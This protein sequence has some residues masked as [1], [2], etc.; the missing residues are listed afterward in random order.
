MCEKQ[1]I[2]NSKE[3]VVIICDYRE[4]GVNE[5]LKK[6]GA[7]VNE[8]NLECGD[9]I[10]SKRVVIER[11]SYDDFISSIFNG[12]IFEQASKLKKNFEKPI[13]LIEGYS[14]REIN[15]NSLKATIASLV[16]DFGISLI[17][18]RNELDTAKTIYWIARKEQE[19]KKFGLA[20]KVGKKPED[21]NKIKEF[22]VSGIPGISTVLSKRL[23]E[24]FGSVEKVFSADEKELKSVKGIGEKLAK[25]IKKILTEKYEVKT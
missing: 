8:M 16:I 19:E 17:S 6:T 2:L 9:F 13:I 5:V 3:K 24:K 11:K 20:F 21:L 7:I 22:I 10:C 23:L 18:T 4:K 12:R 14:T 1:T 15:E 25:K